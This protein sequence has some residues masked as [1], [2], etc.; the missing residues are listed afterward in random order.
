MTLTDR[1]LLDSADVSRQRLDFVWIVTAIGA[2]HICLR[3][4]Q[5]VLFS[6]KLKEESV[7]MLCAAQRC[8]RHCHV[9]KNSDAKRAWRARFDCRRSPAATTIDAN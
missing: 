5:R 3:K 4:V 6:R 8:Y 1:Y 2:T 9:R 7:S